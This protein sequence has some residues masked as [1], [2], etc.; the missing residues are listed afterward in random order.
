M[1]FRNKIITKDKSKKKETVLVEVLEVL[2]IVVVVVV[3]VVLV[4]AIK[5]QKNDIFYIDSFMITCT[6]TCSYCCARS[7]CCRRFVSKNTDKH[8]TKTY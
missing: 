3:V 1:D 7:T 8:S 5:S 6:G 4:D 2:V